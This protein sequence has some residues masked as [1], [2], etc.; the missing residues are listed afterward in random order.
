MATETTSM[1]ARGP[2]GAKVVQ[3]GAREV[4]QG[5]GG[6]A[7]S[8]LAIVVT[9]DGRT[10]LRDC[11]VA[12]SAQSY[13][14]LDVLVVDDASP[15]RR[16]QPAV[17]RIAKRHLERRRWGYLRTA[18]SLGYGGAINWA[19]SRVR[20]DAGLL[21]FLHDDV[22][23][24]REAVTR[25]VERALSDDSIAIVGPKVVTWD[26]PSVLEEVGMAV[27]RFGYPYKGLEQG[28][29]DL[30]QHDTPS[31]VFYVTST[32]M[33][34]KQDVFQSLRGWDSRLGAYAEDLDLCWRAR[35][36]G[37]GVR[38]EPAAVAR[39]AIAMATGRRASR[40]GHARFFIRR[41]RLRTITKNASG[42]RVLVL[43]PQFILLTLL[44]ML[45]FL[46]LRQPREVGNLARALLW[47]LWLL[48]QTLAERWRV[49]KMRKV[50]DKT[51]ARLSVKET[52]RMRVYLGTQAGRLEEAWGRRAEMVARRA[53]RARSMTRRIQGPHVAVGVLAL[54]ALVVG[55]RHFIFSPVASVGELL[56]FPER[57]TSMWRAWAAP[58]R[59]VGLGEPGPAPPAL[60]FLGIFQ[61]ATVG[62]AGAAQKLLITV[63]GVVAFAG[64]HRLVSEIVDR[65]ARLAAGL[66]YA[67]G[68]VGYAGVRSGSLGALVFGAV[69]PF[70]LRSMLRLS[71]WT[72][73]PR[74]SGGREIAR[75][76]LFAA[77]SGAFVPGSLV[78]YG[79]TA[80]LLSLTRSLL[81]R[82]RSEMR[83]FV[84]SI[85]GL[86]VGWALLLP[87]STTWLAEGGAL[88]RL[89]SDATSPVVASGFADHGMASVLLGQTPQGPAL[90]GIAL[91]LL[92]V[93]AVAVGEGQRRR[94]ALALW[95]VVIA[96]GALAT[97]IASG[98]L[99]PVVATPTELGV[100]AALAFAGLAGLAVG[101]FRLD[102][103]RRGL[104]LLQAGALG[105]IAVAAFLLAAGLLPTLWHGE[106]EP[107][108][109]SGGLGRDSV[110]EVG[111]FLQAE[112][113]QNPA[114]RVLWVG[115]G[116]GSP[117]STAALP[118]GDTTVTD[119]R[120]LSLTSL[121]GRSSGPGDRAL[122]SVI[123]SVE[124]GATDR[125]G[126][127]LGAFNIDYI[128][129]ERSSGASEW[130]S[131]GDLGVVSEE[132]GASYLIL[133]NDAR[134]DRAALY[135]RL[136]TSVQAVAQRDPRLL[137]GP[138]DVAR[139]MV[140]RRSSSLYSSSHAEG[141]A[142]VF[143][144]ESNDSRWRGEVAGRALGRAP[145]GWGNAFVITSGMEGPIELDYGRSLGE[146]LWIAVI[147][148][149][150]VFIAGAA[151]PGR[152]R[153]HPRPRRVGS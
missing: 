119:A 39:H 41:N 107:G 34:I 10:W 98:A 70:A 72:R 24:S 52:T 143:L 84:G 75:L 153:G 110:Q 134:L 9:H 57:A 103:P 17:K 46:V 23:L 47:N 102:L 43:V 8:V 120:G 14:L 132:P 20:T 32:C 45:G 123:G 111:S 18:R 69:A 117:D 33:L 58:W 79:V 100:M 59:D 150:W 37:R 7:P 40:F 83:A 19:L 144:A 138:P 49:Q 125:A 66:V 67:L 95:A 94:A 139:A 109:G 89:T 127:L 4:D 11:L 60:F 48:P 64:A 121:F 85:A 77:L 21:L 114:F 68:A 136:P 91:P 87:W 151:F 115:P 31:E 131:Q 149:L 44:E 88:N 97:A 35:L 124:S 145:G 99:P 80:A 86:V 25:M 28:E 141:P 74:W 53:A 106:W 51:L 30:G 27:D 54:I 12:L 26:D 38:L 22:E 16:E 140:E 76:G 152:A 133:E 15:S 56:P 118:V 81:G 104:G 129:L 55:F 126:R 2:R 63:L 50:S 1:L 71:G 29:I 112:A 101:G 42:P 93:I 90:F 116:W 137:S 13:G 130:L 135:D 36:T 61:V 122:R 73:P 105:G 6:H 3:R 5:R 128:V 148:L 142:T 108:G 147:F 78:L 113:L 82:P 96:T 65:P 62:A 146:L 92:G